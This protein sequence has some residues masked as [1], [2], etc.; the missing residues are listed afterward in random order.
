MTLVRSYV[1]ICAKCCSIHE[2]GVICPKCGNN[3]HAFVIRF[4]E[5][6][7]KGKVYNKKLIFNKNIKLDFD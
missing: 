7:R 5:K 1:R 6:V 4:I 3:T 2:Y